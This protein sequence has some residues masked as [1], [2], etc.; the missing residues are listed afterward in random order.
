MIVTVEPAAY[1]PSA[2][3]AL[4]L[5]ILG[6]EPSTLTSAVLP[7]LLRVVAALLPA[8]SRS[9]PPLTDSAPMVMPLASTSPLGTV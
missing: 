7:T 3:L 4:T 6:L 5:V 8:A 1:A 9:V 2:V